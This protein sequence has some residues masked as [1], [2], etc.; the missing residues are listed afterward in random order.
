MNTALIK[1]IALA[2]FFI[3]SLILPQ[4][5]EAFKAMELDP[6]F[7]NTLIW[8]IT[9]VFA[10]LSKAPNLFLKFPSLPKKEEKK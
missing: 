5:A 9:A 2:V 1:K 7:W 10:W 3:A 6:E 8:I 4:Y